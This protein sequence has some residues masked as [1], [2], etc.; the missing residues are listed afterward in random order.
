M[1]ALATIVRLSLVA[2]LLGVAAPIFGARGLGV[3][4]VADSATMAMIESRMRD[5]YKW[6]VM[7]SAMKSDTDAQ[8]AARCLNA[9]IDIA[10]GR[11]DD[12]GRV[13]DEAVGHWAAAKDPKRVSL[14]SLVY[15][16]KGFLEFETAA[17]PTDAYNKRAERLARSVGNIPVEMLALMYRAQ[18]YI[19]ASRHV[20]A[21][22]CAR[23]LLARS[24]AGVMP[25]LRFWG[26]LLLMRNYQALQVDAAVADCAEQIDREGYYVGR[27]A[28]EQYYL[29]TLAVVS[30]ERGDP[31][32]ALSS[33]E[34]ALALSSETHTA[35]TEVWR[36]EIV[37]A[38]ALVG[39]GRFAKAREVLAYLRK[40]AHIVPEQVADPHYA[41]HCIVLVEAQM[42]LA[43]RRPAEAIRILTDGRVPPVMLTRSSFAQKYYGILEDAHLAMGNF[44]AARRTLAV[45]NDSKLAAWSSVAKARAKDME[46]AFREDTTILRQRLNIFDGEARV[47]GMERQVLTISTAVVAAL[48]LGGLVWLYRLRTGAARK[49]RS[50]ALLRYRLNGEIERQVRAHKKVNNDIMRR[51]AELA[52]S[53]TYG[54][55]LQRG[56]LPREEELLDMGVSNAFIIRGSSNVTSGCFYWF[57]K[58]GGNLLICCAEADW[59]G[60]PGAMLSMVGI[61]LADEV[62]A[63]YD[64]KAGAADLLADIE[65]DYV[66]R[67]PDRRWRCDMSMVVAVVDLSSLRVRLAAAGVDAIVRTGGDAIVVRGAERKV[68]AGVE[69]RRL[70]D[71]EFKLVSCDS[72]YFFSPSLLRLTGGGDGAALGVE[73]VRKIIK[74]VTLL[75]PGLR[76]EAVLNEL[77]LWKSGRPLSDDFLLLSVSM[78]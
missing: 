21:G 15:L 51:N 59:D 58:V 16:A 22:H 18:I 10:E 2:A 37:H 6:A 73:G 40:H 31:G 38:E 41:R 65:H 13:L 12:A 20:E 32:E 75:P 53:Q 11:Y 42:A 3:S 27:K 7:L 44:A 25:E 50:M 43:Q 1:S 24:P 71:E 28:L 26:R 56:V 19:R 8:V 33:I 78:P 29:R 5:A 55:Q 62:A 74:R 57:R 69:P 66:R 47:V 45:A 9:C 61:T 76:R 17:D 77:L 35:L 67:L 49:R 34:R 72:L 68:G 52:A 48:L 30:L 39:V 46:I 23:T 4:E 14:L 36:I 54:R 63:H 60:V 64:G 70:A